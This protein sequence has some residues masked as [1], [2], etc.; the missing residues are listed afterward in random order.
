MWEYLKQLNDI[1]H[2]GMADNGGIKAA[3][4]GSTATVAL[5][6]KDRLVVANV[7]DSRLVLCRNGRA[8]DVTTEH[9]LYGKVILF[10]TLSLAWCYVL[11]M[12]TCGY[13]D[14]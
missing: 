13:N 1:E 3:R 11:K 14:L 12:L 10:S 9:R 4:S 2:S 7:G 5:I 8:F 6:K